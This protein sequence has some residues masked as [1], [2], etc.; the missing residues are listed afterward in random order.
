MKT[1]PLTYLVS[2]MLGHSNKHTVQAELAGAWPTH[3]SVHAAC[4]AAER[5]LRAA[6]GWVA[7]AKHCTHAAS[8]LYVGAL[9]HRA[10][11]AS[12]L[13]VNDQDN[14]Q[15]HVAFGIWHSVAASSTRSMCNRCLAPSKTQRLH[16][17]YKAWVCL[18]C[19]GGTQGMACLQQAYIARV[20]G[21]MLKHLFSVKVRTKGALLIVETNNSFSSLNT[22]KTWYEK[23]FNSPNTKAAKAHG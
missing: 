18:P 10:H 2:H 1:V 21:A 22:R 4:I 8:T 12:N 16:Q 17:K 11:A 6:C 20:R 15:R 9:Q 13:W 23:L 7:R 19:P 14:Y 5:M 3:H